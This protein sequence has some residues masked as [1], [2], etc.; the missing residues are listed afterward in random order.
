MLL[1][2]YLRDGDGYINE[3]GDNPKMD[4]NEIR[5]SKINEG[6]IIDGLIGQ[7][8]NQNN[9]LKSKDSLYKEFFSK[10]GHCSI[11]KVK[12]YVEENELS[13][14]KKDTEGMSV[15]Q[16][17]IKSNP[18]LDVIQYLITK[19]SPINELSETGKTLLHYAAQSSSSIAII[20]FLIK[21]GI[22]INVQS[23]ELVTPLHLASQFNPDINIL[24]YLI[25]KG[26]D[27]KLKNKMGFTW[28]HCAVWNPNIEIIKYVLESEEDV[29][30]MADHGVT[31]L[32]CAAYK[33][34]VKI[35]KYLV[36]MG[37]D[38]KNSGLSLSP[39]D[40]AKSQKSIDFVIFLESLE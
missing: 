34:N 13:V 40:A 18:N 35:G 3:Y 38:Y 15:L 16:I 33:N 37:A 24:T 1:V 14:L 20:D 5:H 30:T 8:Q 27:T 11:E 7:N 39:M 25:S 36:E 4:Y 32:C 19:G 6:S 21:S 12:F 17:A 23:Y 26:A 9:K 2:W 31:P 22:D 10:I 29:N 28:L